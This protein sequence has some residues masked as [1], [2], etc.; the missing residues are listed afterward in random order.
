MNPLICVLEAFYWLV[1]VDMMESREKSGGNA[2]LFLHFGRFSSPKLVFVVR[3]HG[4]NGLQELVQ[5]R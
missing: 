2:E 5:T 4:T 1:V 3:E